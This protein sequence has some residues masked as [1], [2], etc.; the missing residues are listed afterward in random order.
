MT[1]E[2]RFQIPATTDHSRICRR[3]LIAYSLDIHGD[4]EIT[5]HGRI[6]F[7][8]MAM[9]IQIQKESYFG[10]KIENENMEL[11]LIKGIN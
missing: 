4:K 6:R 3:Q 2:N 9:P 1:Q 8:Q 10:Q 11:D 7:S 5:R